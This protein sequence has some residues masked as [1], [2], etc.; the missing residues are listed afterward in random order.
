MYTQWRVPQTIQWM[1]A[2]FLIYLA[3]FTG[4]RIATVILFKP[5]AYEISSLLPSFWL[6]LKYD[7]RWIAIIL[8]PIAIAS[9]FPA[10]SPFYSDRNK[11]IW[12]AY[13]GTITLA[14]LLFFGADLAQFAYVNAR[15]NADSLI[16]AED[17]RESLTMI[18][19]SYPIVWILM[20]L[21]GAVAMGT[22]IFRRTHVTVQ[23]RNK[24]IHK[25]DYRRRWHLAALLL[26]GWF[27]WGFFMTR[28]LN[29]FKAFSLND[30]FKSNLALNPMQNFFTTL[31]FRDPEY[32]TNAEE[33]FETMRSYLNLPQE[34][35]EK[36]YRRKVLPLNNG[37]ESRPNIVLVICESFSMYKSSLSGNPLDASPYIKGL[38]EQGVMFNRCFT[39]SFGTARGVFATITGTPDVQLGKFATRNEAT[40]KQRTIINDFEG[41]DKYYYIG[42][43][44]QFNNFGGL[45]KN[46]EGIKIFE[47]GSYTSPEL[48]VW[49]ISDKDLFL[50]ANEN[51]K[52]Q[53]KP[54]FAVIQ[55]ADNHRPFTIPENEPGFDKKTLH[56]DS[57]KKYGFESNEEFNAF[58]YMDYSIKTFMEAAKKEKYFHNTI[59]V[60]IG[61]HG[62]EGNA[63]AVYP[64]AWTETRL[65]D[66]HV[67]LLFYSPGMLT[68]AVH[69]A[70][71]SQID[72]LPTIAGLLDRPYTN[73]T[74]G[75]DLFSPHKGEN[76]A[77]IIYHASGWIG[78]VNDHF[79]YRRN[80]RMKLEEL[81]PLGK[82]PPMNSEQIDSVKA[83]LGEL[84]TAI[85][86]TSRWMLVNN[87]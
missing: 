86:E 27:L 78:I 16:F 7:V 56:A 25:F 46:V 32:H 58:S 4:F 5:D 74:I 49:G 14:V 29:F 80:I 77:F 42:G 41:Y 18:W 64:A 23:Q 26:I 63:R 50:A 24:H 20:A 60:F 59:F 62:V 71:V 51:F 72:V 66:N 52:T 17:P 45:M 13:L 12:T 73:T 84:S 85:Y 61:D 75:R 40:V 79:Y 68:P 81:H 43:R 70:A 39:P 82:M 9:L 1:V 53:K 36:N 2:L 34:N 35:N 47:E 44:S 15:L 48:N 54:F 6:G 87:K 76:A 30:E 8:L 57:L 55:T 33:H 83:H 69:N 65:T 38:A 31:R 37:I 3:I 10:L 22:W 19:Q 67:P 28:P 11:R 21:F